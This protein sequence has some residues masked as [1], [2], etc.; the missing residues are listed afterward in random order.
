[1][2]TIPVNMGVNATKEHQAVISKLIYG[3]MG[4]FTKGEMSLF[5]CPETMIN[6]AETSPSPDIL[7][8]DHAI[9]KT[10]VIIEINH[11]EGLKKDAKNLEELIEEYELAEGFLYDY[12][13]KR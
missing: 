5:P 1:M 12:K 9:N 10:A 3:L 2:L 6:E 8:F 4:L 7:L 11:P 13:T